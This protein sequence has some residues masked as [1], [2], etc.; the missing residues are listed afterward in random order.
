MDNK[1]AAFYAKIKKLVTDFMAYCDLSISKAEREARAAEKAAL[2]AKESAEVAAKS[3]NL[4]IVNVLNY[5]AWG[6]GEHDDTDA[7]QTALRYAEDNELPLYIPAGVYK[8]SKTISTYKR[9]DFDDDTTMRATMATVL[10]I[11]GAGMSTVIKTTEDFDGDYIFYIDVNR[12]NDRSLWLHDFRINNYGD[13]SGIFLNEVGMKTVIENLWFRNYCQENSDIRCAIRADQSTVVTYQRIKIWGNRTDCGIVIGQMH[14]SKIIDCDVT[15]CKYA[16]YLSGGS[17]NQVTNCRIDENY[18]GIYQNSSSDIEQDD[19]VIGFR[20]SFA[21]FTVKGNRFE[22]NH[23][24][25]IYLIPYGHNDLSNQSVTISENYFTGLCTVEKDGTTIKRRAIR[26]GRING[27][28]ITSNYFKG[29]PYVSDAES[30]DAQNISHVSEINHIVLMN[31]VAAQW[32][33]NGVKVKSSNRIS[34]D[35]VSQQRIISNIELNQSTGVTTYNA[36]H[37]RG[38]TISADAPDVSNGNVFK[39][40]SGVTVSSFDTSGYDGLNIIQEITLYAVGT[41]TVKYNSTIR[42]SGGVDFVMNKYDTLTLIRVYDNG[43]KWVEKCRTVN[44]K[45]T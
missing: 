10:Q 28:T 27:L 32:D 25:S 13:T 21:N 45:T 6:D 7:I 8:V 44:S 36:T 19:N 23:K 18:Y 40:N 30:D 3:G 4:N 42:L 35:F 15:Y 38:V 39:V 12:P 29:D 22:N 31:N 11:Y 20:G 43:V 37:I 41:A 16:I 1:L 24:Y 34:A 9:E 26:V 14:S 2:A 5:G 33:D 17:N